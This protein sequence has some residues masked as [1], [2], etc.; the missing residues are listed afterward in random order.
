L[1]IE[2]ILVIVGMMDV[3]VV[4]FVII[5]MVKLW[6]FKN[7][8]NQLP[9]EFYYKFDFSYSEKVFFSTIVRN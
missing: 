7:F 3:M 2:R 5:I 9:F 1:I 8:G 6:G 4:M